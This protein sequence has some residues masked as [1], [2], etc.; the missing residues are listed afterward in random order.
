MKFWLQH[1]FSELLNISRSIFI[2]L[3]NLVLFS[4]MNNL[5]TTQV[6]VLRFDLRS[7]RVK[8]LKGTHLQIIWFH[9]CGFDS[10]QFYPNS[11]KC[12]LGPVVLKLQI[13]VGISHKCTEVRFAS[14][15]S[16]GFI[17]A[18]IVNPPESKLEKRTSVQYSGPFFTC[19]I[20]QE[21]GW[22]LS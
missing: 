9:S 6:F 20:E 4:G 7:D 21:V 5:F 3:D 14:F 15:L 13:C 2:W 17:T 16:G 1:C 12:E 8:L 22:R 19:Y 11:K 10:C 18:L